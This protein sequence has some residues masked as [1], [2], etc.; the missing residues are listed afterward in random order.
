MKRKEKGVIVGSSRVDLRYRITLTKPVPEILSIE[1]GDLIVFRRSPDR[2]IYI[3]PSKV[4][5]I[6]KKK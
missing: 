5:K 4:A 6:I 3:E 1:S 2:Q